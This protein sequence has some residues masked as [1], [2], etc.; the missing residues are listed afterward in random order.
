MTDDQI[1]DVHIED[2]EPKKERK[3][4]RK[5]DKNQEEAN[6]LRRQ[7]T[8]ANDKYLR[9]LAEF[10][11]F[12][13]RTSREKATLYDDGVVAS[14]QRFLPVIDNFERAMT[15]VD[16]D[17][18]TAKGFVMILRQMRE[19]LA[20]MGVSEIDAAGKMFDPNLHNAVMMEESDK[21]ES[22]TVSEE[23]MKGY[24]YKDKPIRHSMVKVI[25]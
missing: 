8:E 4:G 12:R 17:D 13:K 10:D 3:R 18:N 14:V 1:L 23:L 21:Y 15:L 9:V 16:A 19:I 24:I 25:S 6:E 2:G 22:G 20:A 5:Q 11:N 7:A